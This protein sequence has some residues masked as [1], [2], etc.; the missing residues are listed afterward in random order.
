[1][2]NPIF[3]RIISLSPRLMSV[4]AFYFVQLLSASSYLLNWMLTNHESLN[5][6][7][8]IFSIYSVDFLKHCLY[9]S[10]MESPISG[11]SDYCGFPREQV[12]QMQPKMPLGKRFTDSATLTDLI[13]FPPGWLVKKFKHT[14]KLKEFFS[15]H[16]YAHHLGSTIDTVPLSIHHSSHST[17][18]SVS[19]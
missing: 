9:Y 1:M 7:S 4:R 10:V 12:G 8:K 5:K 18:L 17:I 2:T 6:T 3:A 13:S 16:P 15:K 19:N 11:L 14:E